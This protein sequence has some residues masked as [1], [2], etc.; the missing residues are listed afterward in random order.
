M[1]IERALVTGGAGFIGSHLAEEL[2]SKGIAVTILDNLSTGNLA[3]LE[4]IQNH[5]TFIQG[6]IQDPGIV[7]TSVKGQDAVFHLAAQVSVTRSV[8]DP[9]FSAMTNDIGFLNILE[10]GRR[11]H[12]KRVV[13]SSSCAVY[14]D[15]PELP[16]KEH[17][18][19]KPLSPY[20]LQKLT[21]ERYARLYYDLH[22]LET[23]CLRYFNVYGPRQDSSSPYS[24]VISL[25][26][27]RALSNKQPVIYGD[28]LQYRDFVYVKD[29]VNAN[30]LSATM[31]YPGKQVFNIGTGK[32]VNINEL[33]QKIS[34]FSGCD[35][36]PYYQSPR[37]GDIRESVADINLAEK[38]LG[39]SPEYDFDKGL[40]LTFNWYK[41]HQYQTN[42]G[43]N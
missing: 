26:M 36:K 30:W 40:E 39:F 3:N 23:I 25:F 5:I 33:W 35:Q 19:P 11:H 38:H 37:P 8:E 41:D 34:H 10:A 16:K 15:D 31:A 32:I 12:I 29:V 6:D 42:T 22:S 1:K 28:G 4:P 21:G 18:G 13:F 27:T 7:E 9:V 17:I 24:G 14:G 20:A 43:G 2:V